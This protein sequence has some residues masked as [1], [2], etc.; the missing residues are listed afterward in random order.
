[1]NGTM[2]ES[3]QTPEPIEYIPSSFFIYLITTARYRIGSDEFDA[4]VTPFCFAS[5]QI[6]K[7]MNTT[8][9]T[10]ALLKRH[11]WQRVLSLWLKVASIG[12]L[13]ISRSLDAAEVRALLLVGTL[14]VFGVSILIGRDADRLFKKMIDTYNESPPVACP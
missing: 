2:S 6:V 3:K 1:M 10:A 5:P 4:Y 7:L 8:A 9:D 14:V 12:A 13:G 11:E